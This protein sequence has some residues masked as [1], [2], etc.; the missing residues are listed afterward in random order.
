MTLHI[1]PA[2][3][4]DYGH[5]ERLLAE[6]DAYH[7]RALHDVFHVTSGAARPLALFRE[8][9]ETPNRHL[10]LAEVEAMVVGAVL[11]QVKATPANRPLVMIDAL[12]VTETQRRAG[13]GQA[14]MEAVHHWAGERGIEDFELNV[15]AF[16]E[17]A[18]QLYRKLGYQPLWLRMRRGTAHPR[19]TR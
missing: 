1:R 2:T 17:A 9:L 6:G 4:A 12:L 5:F 3:A 18:Q 14:L 13:I 10:W 8:W 15:Y 11:F 16:N 7:K 19:R